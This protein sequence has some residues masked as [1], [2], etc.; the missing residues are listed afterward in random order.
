MVCWIYNVVDKAAT[1]AISCNRLL[2]S[3]V[4]HYI[5]SNAFA[6]FKAFVSPET[7]FYVLKMAKAMTR[8]LSSGSPSTSTKHSV[9]FVCQQ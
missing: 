8:C 5:I 6:V 3:Y 2:Q 9:T 1:I 4:F 7:D